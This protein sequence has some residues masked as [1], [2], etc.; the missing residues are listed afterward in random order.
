MIREK[1]Q[2]I[3]ELEHNHQ[4]TN[5]SV[6]ESVDAVDSKSTGSNPVGVRVSPEA[7][8]Y[9]RIVIF[10]EY[11]RPDKSLKGYAANHLTLK[12]KEKIGLGERVRNDQILESDLF[13]LKWYIERDFVLNTNRYKFEI[14]TCA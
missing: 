3:D 4:N 14:V 2:N 6:A 11:G 13:F 9:F 7:P 1:L 5:A 12:R 10:D 8:T